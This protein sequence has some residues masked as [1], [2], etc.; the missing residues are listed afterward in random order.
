MVYY[1]NTLPKVGEPLKNIEDIH[2]WV[3]QNISN[4]ND[5]YKQDADKTKRKINFEEREFVMAHLCKGRFPVGCYSKLKNQNFGPCQITKKINDN[6]YQV[7]LPEEFNMSF[8]FNVVDLRKL[9]QR[10]G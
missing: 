5:K 9:S 1:L 3:K 4:S 6:G 7:D 2:D 8:T 10:K